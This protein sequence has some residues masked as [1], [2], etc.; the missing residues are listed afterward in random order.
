VPWLASFEPSGLVRFQFGANHFLERLV[1]AIDVLSNIRVYSNRFN[2]GARASGREAV[3]PLEIRIDTG[4]G[5]E[6]CCVLCASSRYF[7]WSPPGI[8]RRTQLGRSRS[9]IPFPSRCVANVEKYSTSNVPA[10]EI[11]GRMRQRWIL[12]ELPRTRKAHEG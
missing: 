11:V 1:G 2:P 10:L 12:P 8:P 9:G 5:R 7:R 4:A 6:R 3:F